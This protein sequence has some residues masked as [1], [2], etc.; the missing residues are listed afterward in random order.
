MHCTP[1][2][3]SLTHS[4]NRD[5]GPQHLSAPGGNG[6]PSRPVICA[7]VRTTVCAYL[8]SQYVYKARNSEELRLGSTAGATT[9]GGEFTQ[10]VSAA[11]RGLHRFRQS[12]CIT[13]NDFSSM[14]AM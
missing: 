3:R 14:N 4:R 10:G 9:S 13:T 2:L 8:F 5:R 11:A 7:N 1:P 12:M 6:N